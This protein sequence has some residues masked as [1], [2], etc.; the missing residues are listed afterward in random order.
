MNI[1]KKIIQNIF[2]TI[3]QIEKNT[4]IKIKA[5]INRYQRSVLINLDISENFISKIL[6]EKIKIKILENRN[7]TVNRFDRIKI[8]YL[9]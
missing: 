8:V 6:A 1:I 4:T 5:N 3:V 9:I 7:I 2:Y